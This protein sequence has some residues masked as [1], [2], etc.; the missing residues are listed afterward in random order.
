MTI[1]RFAAAVLL[2]AGAWTAPAAAAPIAAVGTT[3]VT[4]SD[5]VL[6]FLDENGIAP[7]AIDPAGLS[8]ATFSFPITGGE[9]ETLTI[10]HSGGVSLSAG[11]AV[12]NAEN[13]TIKG[14]ELTVA[15]D[16]SGTAFPTALE[17]VDIFGLTAVDLSGPI[18]A[19]LVINETLNFAL[20]ATFADGADLQLTDVVF[21]TASTS[22]QPV[23]LPAAAPLLLA[24]LAGFALLRRRAT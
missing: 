10:T 11:T 13:F 17:Q 4:V 3:D 18:T 16:V 1:A 8:G 12:L 9:T 24:G 19:D 22:P 21:G 6:G 20:G 7:S 23:P 5:T 15:A 2:A 14:N